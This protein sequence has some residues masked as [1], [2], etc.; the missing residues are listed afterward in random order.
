MPA[1]S[2]PSGL[3]YGPVGSNAVHLCIDMQRLFGPGTPWAVPWMEKVLPTISRVVEGHAEQTI[4][5][6]FVPMANAEH[7]AG[8]WK[9]YYQRWES[10]TLDRLDPALIDLAPQLTRYVPPARVV[11]KWVYSPWTEGKLDAMLRG[12]S[13]D[14][15]L[16][17]GGETDVCVL[18]A[19]LGAVDR[20]Y[21]VIVISDGMCSSAD[22]SHD[23][24]LTL[25][26]GRFGQQIEVAEA[27][28]VLESWEA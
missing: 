27:Q 6:R 7:A 17:S 28:E 18:A 19:V 22:E 21:R 1:P 13:V 15:I 10:V 23:A 26:S 9:R 4:F 14:T 12:T 24:L 25:Y 3:L 20:G 2:K 8:T 5:T 16:M 11:D